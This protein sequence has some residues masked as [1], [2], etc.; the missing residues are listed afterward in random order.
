MSY[1]IRG[2]QELAAVGSPL[3][4][5]FSTL[6][7]RV[8]WSVIP[9]ILILS[10]I[11]GATN[12]YEYRQ[13]ITQEFMKRGASMASNLAY[14]SELGVFSE[15][16]QLLEAS[17][18]GVLRDADTAYVAIYGDGGKLLAWRRLGSGSGEDHGLSP[19]EQSRLAA[20]QKA[21]LNAPAS[22][23]DDLI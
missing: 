23:G 16:Q 22:I 21:F 5:R 7:S 9:V 18:R 12:V 3:R 15:D 8:F 1:F 2:E 14:S 17:L 6:S 11:V 10:I 20:E 4:L 13:L 19:E